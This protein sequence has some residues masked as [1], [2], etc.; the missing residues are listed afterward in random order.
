ML[1]AGWMTSAC[2]NSAGFAPSDRVV[3]ADAQGLV[4]NLEATIDAIEGDVAGQD[5]GVD[6]RLESCRT[7]LALA[8]DAV[9]RSTTISAADLVEMLEPFEQRYGSLVAE[10]TAEQ[11]LGPPGRVRSPEEMGALIRRR[12]KAAVPK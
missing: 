5:K 1:L 6:Q 3:I 7:A 12:V 2:V 8:R 11:L 10:L 4:A 9:N